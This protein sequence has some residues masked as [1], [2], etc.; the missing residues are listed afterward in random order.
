MVQNLATSSR[1][2]RWRA[3]AVSL[4]IFAVAAV[5]SAPL[6]LYP[7]VLSFLEKKISEAAGV[8]VAAEKLRAGFS[9]SIRLSGITIAAPDSIEY[10]KC[11]NLVIELPLLQTAWRY[12]S[13]GEIIVREVIVDGLSVDLPTRPP[14][15]PPSRTATPDPDPDGDFVALFRRLVSTTCG[16]SAFSFDPPDFSPPVDLSIKRLRL[17]GSRVTVGETTL[18][19]S[20]DC[21]LSLSSA[22]GGGET[23]L[24]VL[25][26]SDTAPPAGVMLLAACVEIAF[27]RAGLRCRHLSIRTDAGSVNVAGAAGN[28]GGRGCGYLDFKLRFDRIDPAVFIDH[29]T[30]MAGHAAGSAVAVDPDRSPPAGSLPEVVSAASVDPDRSPPAGSLPAVGSAVADTPGMVAA[31]ASRTPG[32]V[33]A[34][35]SRTPGMVAAP[36]SRTRRDYSLFDGGIKINRTGSVVKLVLDIAG[37]PP[38]I[39][40]GEVH[41]VLKLDGSG[42]FSIDTLTA[43]AAGASMRLA[44][45]LRQVGEAL[46]LEVSGRLTGVNAGLVPT[47]FP[48]NIETDL[49][50]D[51]RGGL[52]FRDILEQAHIAVDDFHGLVN[53]REIRGG[54]LKAAWR[55]ETGWDNRGAGRL[56]LTGGWSG[57]EAS[58]LSVS[59]AL[60][61][62]ESLDLSFAFT[63]GDDDPLAALL[64]HEGENY[65]GRLDAEG[66]IKGSWRDPGITIGVEAT[67]FSRRDLRVE[68]VYVRAEGK[69]LAQEPRGRASCS[70][71]GIEIGALY[72][73][74]ATVDAEYD[75]GTVYIDEFTLEAHDYCCVM[76][77]SASLGESGVEGAVDRAVIRTPDGRSIRTAKIPFGASTGNGEY[78]AGPAA[79]EFPGGSAVFEASRSGATGETGLTA[80]VVCF[81]LSMIRHPSVL[82]MTG[83]IDF[84]IDVALHPDA[85][86]RAAAGFSCRS[87]VAGDAVID[88]IHAAA[89]LDRGV[90][91]V[92]RLEAT[93]CGGTLEGA[94]EIP[95]EI[96][97]ADRSATSSTASYNVDAAWRSLDLATLSTLLPVS[98]DLGGITS[99]NLG[100]TGA[101]GTP[102]DLG[103]SVSAE[104]FRVKGTFFDNV[105]VDLRPGAPGRTIVLISGSSGGRPMA[106]SGVIP[107]ALDLSAPPYAVLGDSVVLNVS[108]LDLDAAFLAGYIGSVNTTEGN[109]AFNGDIVLGGVFPFYLRGAAAIENGR[110]EIVGFKDPVGSL[111]GSIRM[112]AEEWSIGEVRGSIGGGGFRLDGTMVVEGMKPVDADLRIK[113]QSLPINWIKDF[114]GQADGVLTINGLKNGEIRGKVFL[115]RGL[116]TTEFRKEAGRLIHPKERGFIF[117]IDVSA[118]RNLWLKN[119]EA[120]VELG[121]EITL[122][123]RHGRTGITGEL[124]ILRGKYFLLRRNKFRVVDG[125]ILFLDPTRIDPVLDIEAET[126]VRE[127]FVDLS[128]EVATEEVPITFKMEGGLSDLQLSFYS[129]GEPIPEE[130]ALMLIMFHRREIES[131]GDIFESGNIL[132][133]AGVF[134]AAILEERFGE[135]LDTVE[136][137]PGADSIDETLVGVGKYV[138]DN[139]YIRY[140]QYLAA[141]PRSHVGFEYRINRFLSVNGAVEDSE[142][143]REYSVDLLLRIEY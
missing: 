103:G 32:M 70:L 91:Y 102:A 60:H 86:P 10:V 41:A 26:A 46:D 5:F 44:G 63:I 59:G 52:R 136:I 17:R 96:A 117:D 78:F 137:E 2:R 113:Y 130:E 79:L 14:P 138:S 135:I 124:R 125:T 139:L 110:V 106:G 28:A 92:E 42:L 122:T 140:S 76:S 33:V 98:L 43:A 73:D 134:G 111:R 61:P 82:P 47:A 93:L 36:A 83:Q 68:R 35:A 38:G 95:L 62:E 118:P 45:E 15:S 94:A 97:A 112:G 123:N 128:G 66:C 65:G 121:G 57:V 116:L 8:A 126:T 56:E 101:P 11:A 109:L 74:E 39:G 19:G 75:S 142:L 108:V 107:F 120:E 64:F 51:I 69:P 115:S 71:E 23:R 81:P 105:A 132:A 127:R 141:N 21:D 20:L 53:H 1:K 90:L 77:G 99:G 131:A 4:V 49:S 40:P 88:S 7:A 13:E 87:L 114:D 104:N 133:N 55:G 6:W 25:R 34:P 24:A 12:L 16:D 18:F 22:S 30:T 129:D 67:G 27:D 48:D 143:G 29:F 84:G 50:A 31:P 3:A 37:D 54:S 100:I 89:R 80:A 72:M 9:G 119:S 58:G 85:P